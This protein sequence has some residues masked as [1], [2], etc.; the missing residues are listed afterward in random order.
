MQTRVEERARS[1]MTASRSGAWSSGKRSTICAPSVTIKRPDDTDS[2]TGSGRST[3]S[4][5]KVAISVSL[6]P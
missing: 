3:G 6:A 2:V 4:V 5:L 1:G